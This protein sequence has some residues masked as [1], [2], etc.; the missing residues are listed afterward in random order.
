METTGKKPDEIKSESTAKKGNV[1]LIEA[2]EK[3][4]GE[5][6][7]PDER[8]FLDEDDSVKEKDDGKEVKKALDKNFK[9]DLKKE[10]RKAKIAFL[11]KRFIGMFKISS[12]S[13]LFRLLDFILNVFS[14]SAIIFGVAITAKFLMDGNPYMVVA[15]C[16]FIFIVIYL[17]EKIMYAER[18]RFWVDY[19]MKML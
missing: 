10:N 18:K 3:E 8:F 13:G 15:G 14:I 1:L 17:N 4:N 12:L 7:S 11:Q 19:F 9:K 2:E 16:V 6:I 5:K